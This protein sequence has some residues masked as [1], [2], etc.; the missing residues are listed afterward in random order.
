MKASIIVLA[1][2]VCVGFGTAQTYKN[3]SSAAKEILTSYVP[4]DEVLK[5][6]TRNNN[7]GNEDKANIKKS[8]TEKLKVLFHH[9]SYADFAK[10]TFSDA[11]GNLYVSRKGNI[12]FIN[13][14]DLNFDGYPEVVMNNDHNG[15]D[16]P[17]ALIYH[18]RLPN[19]LH[20]LISPVAQDG[21]VY[22]NLKY[23]LESL[24][25]ITQLPSEGGGKAVVEDINKDGFK[26]LI[27]TNFIHGSTLQEFPAY[28]YWG[29]SDGFNPARRSLLPADRGTAAAIADLNNDGLLD[30]VVA[31]SGREH[32]SAEPA[33][34]SYS[35]LTK[36]GGEREKTSYI[37][38][39]SE[40]GFS[41]NS[42]QAIP[43]QYAVDVKVADITK[44]G[45]NALIFLE[46]GEPGAI[47]IIPQKEGKWAEPQLIPVLAVKTSPSNGK[48]INRELLVKDLNGDSY[49]DIF[50]PSKG[51]QSEIFWNRKGHF[52]AENKTV[53]EADNAFSADAA[54]LNKDGYV[55][56]V[57]ANF[58][59]DDE[60]GNALFETN[61]HIWWGGKGGFNKS[62]RTALPTWGA[63]SVK[64]ADINNTGYQDILFAQH[65]NQEST[66]VPSFIYFNSNKGF[67]ADNR[68]EL[69]GFGAVS[70]L[71]EDFTGSKRKDV[72]LINSLS[73]QARHAGI[74]DEPGN[75]GV[76][77]NALPMYIYKGNAS[78]KYNNSNLMRIPESAQETNISFADMNDDG[79]ADLVQMRGGGRRLLI[80]Y[81]I[82]N[83]PKTKEFVEMDVPFRG[84]TVN[85]ADYNKD[86]F[87]DVVITPVAG[88]QGAI[89]LGLGNGKYRSTLFDFQ[90]M[91]YAASVGDVNN[92]GW[93]DIVTCG[94]SQVSILLGNNNGDFHFDEPI[95]I[96]TDVFTTRVSM[97]DFNKDGWLDIFCQN[98][99]KFE[100]KTYDIESWVLINNKGKFSV[101]NKRT[102]HTFGAN[103]GSIAQL[104]DDGK[105]DVIVSNY[106]A[107]VSRRVGTFILS[108]DK[109]GFPTE[110]GKLRL[111][112]YSSGANVVLDFN[113]DG[114]QDILVYNHTGGEVYNGTL[115]PTGGVHGVGSNLFWGSKEGYSLQNTSYIPSFGPH[116]RIIADPG[117][118]ARRNP[119][120]IY[121]SDYILNNFG[122]NKFNLSVNGRFNKKQFSTLEIIIGDQNSKSETSRIVPKLVSQSD[123]S[124]SYTVSIP[125]GKTFRYRLTLNSSHSGSGPVVSSVRME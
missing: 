102:F 89:F 86:G 119:Y 107:D 28:I 112:S 35:T 69:Q 26:D 91:A 97:A 64:I 29:G 100:S 80:R 27:F 117:S 71:A 18:N 82:Y 93:L 65:R 66:D 87:L 37:F 109:D 36:L 114:F 45:S 74:E 76:T 98:L 84:N 2:L 24:Q 34:F 7:S 95:T 3:N 83:Y 75:E 48:R 20:S 61:S 123:S 85:V 124:E 21:P 46:A 116:S 22:Q 50:A 122:K 68:L 94:Y 101:N 32:L 15:Y 51:K 25:S 52:S 6:T 49:P 19:G 106:H 104:Q 110:E 60:K 10:G 1:G 4:S 88:S 108:D 47:R 103:G 81:N 78:G 33:D 62:K 31:N 90:Q 125:K 105:L 16:T 111:P 57:I 113:G 121:T 11:G 55:D 63:V 12:Q 96:K 67:S 41:I 53:L 5:L 99:Q 70:I 30:I 13:L 118:V 79:K 9:K 8:T 42:R 14:Y 23:T 72:V 77:P 92:D 59:K 115:N 40:G 54:D 39:Q 17:D 73:G 43:T 120:E 56:L 44:S 58:F 38:I